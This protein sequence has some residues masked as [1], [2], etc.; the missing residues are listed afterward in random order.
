MNIN[1]Y[2]S[3]RRKRLIEQLNERFGITEIPNF[4]FVTGKERV[5]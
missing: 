2:D 4:I 3:K 5:R 1:I